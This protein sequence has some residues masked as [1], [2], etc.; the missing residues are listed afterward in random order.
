MARFAHV[1]RKA[2]AGLALPAVHR[3]RVLLE[4]G[5]DL[6]DLY[7][8]L[9]ARGMDE[10]DARARAVA[11]LGPSPEVVR[12]LHAL[13]RPRGVLWLDRTLGHVLDRPSERALFA[14]LAMAGVLGAVITLAVAWPSSG[15][16][17]AVIAIL[18]IG[19]LSIVWTA[20]AWYHLQRGRDQSRATSDRAAP[21]AG[22]AALMIVLGAFAA[23]RELYA[24]CV[25]VASFDAW[26]A[27]L[28]VPV[29]GDAASLLTLAMTSALA[30]LLPWFP[31]RILARRIAAERAVL[32]CLMNDNPSDEVCN[33]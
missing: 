22:L 28:V 7:S 27:S 13:H 24:M 25:R 30:V 33:D 29:L 18:S 19:A 14:V 23:M 21:V 2:E 32:S 4:V 11:L 17:A 6:E 3:G 12:A 20:T 9:C 16:P 15:M 1:L 5:Q 10:A 26:S 31:V 8:A